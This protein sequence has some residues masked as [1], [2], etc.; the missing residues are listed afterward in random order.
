M[1]RFSYSA[2]MHVCLE[3]DWCEE[4]THVCQWLR[5]EHSRAVVGTLRWQSIH[6]PLEEIDVKYPS[7]KAILE[8][9]ACEPSSVN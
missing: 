2:H 3:G 8:G 9:I 7:I 6:I 5:L 4:Y 1:R